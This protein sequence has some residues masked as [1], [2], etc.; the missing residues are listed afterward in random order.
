MITDERINSRM[1]PLII[2]AV[3]KCIDVFQLK[4]I[5]KWCWIM[6]NKNFVKKYP[7][8]LKNLNSLNLTEIKYLIKKRHFIGRRFF[9]P[10]FFIC[11]FFLFTVFFLQ[12]IIDKVNLKSIQQDNMGNF[13]NGQNLKSKLYFCLVCNYISVLWN[14]QC[15]I[16]FSKI[17]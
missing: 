8:T 2:L 15:H 5:E 16:I 1:P 11:I 13:S 3:S 4:Y 10:S 9:F 17:I 14:N 6:K 12:S 7:Y